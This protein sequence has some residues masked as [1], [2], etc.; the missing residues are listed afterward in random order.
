MPEQTKRTMTDRK[1][2]DRF[3]GVALAIGGIALALL[4]YTVWPI[5]NPFVAAIVLYIVLAPFLQYRAAR[6]LLTA[7]FML[8]GIWA[9]V[10]LAGILVPFILG[11]ILAYLFNP[12]VTR[13]QTKRKIGRTWSSLS[14]VII[15]CAVIVAL[16]WIFLPSLGEQT[17]AFIERLTLFVRQNQ[18]TFDERHLRK[19]MMALGLPANIANR[20]ILEQAGPALHKIVAIVPEIIMA[21]IAG[22]PQILERVLNL[23]IVPIAMFY[24]V[25]DWP[26]ILH[27]LN[28]IFPSQDP[29]RRKKIVTDIDRVLYGYVRGQLTVATI[30]GIIGAIAYSILGIPYAGL[31]GVIL[32]IS[33]LV[34]IAGMIFSAL[35]VE[36]VIVL[37][38]EPTLGVI[39]S[40]VL[41]IA[42]LH[43]LEIYVIGPRIIG[44]GIGVPPIIMILSLLVFGFFF[45]FVGLL[46]AV[47]TTGII[48][49][50]VNEFRKNNAAAREKLSALE[51]T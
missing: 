41:V 43:L 31:L 24:F 42:G 37:T 30:I 45:G 6:K 48:L 35:V 26:R 13:L 5:M 20:I 34:P 22:L 2:S 19:L 21:V 4:A 12:L 32:A 29:V 17:K 46:V 39:L 9:A 28:D 8:F 36:L 3:D 11:A 14:V 51:E 16:G 40:G 23:I 7:G 33:D 44:P 1:I 25:K 50:F 38:M 47:P 15:F 49:L 10:T 27:A 18:N